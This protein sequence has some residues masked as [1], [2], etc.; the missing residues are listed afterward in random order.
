MLTVRRDFVNRTDEIS[1]LNRVLASQAGDRDAVVLVHGQRGIGKTQLLGKY[2][3]ESIASRLR[4]AYVDLPPYKYYLGVIDEIVEGLGR[5]GFELL[6][7]TYDDLLRRF[8]AETSGALAAAQGAG[9]AAA[10]QGT[11]SG[12][13]AFHGS[14][15]AQTQQFYAATFKDS[16]VTQ[17][18]NFQINEAK[19]VKQL[20]ETRIT[21]A[22]SDCLREIAQGQ[23][24]IIL[25]DHWEGAKGPVRK[26]LS[27]NLLAWAVE[28]R[29]R[30]AMLVLA[31]ENVPAEYDNTMGIQPLAVPPFSRVAALEFWKRNELAED[32][33]NSL[34]AEVYSI[35]SMLAMEVDTRKERARQA[36][37]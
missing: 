35:P 4:I 29:L 13:I 36:A 14:V 15:T 32:D 34:Q 7:Q 16:K 21:R 22:F 25:L 3:R 9:D 17:I 31:L 23:A 20:I 27:E 6:D 26:W 1:T 28:P 33:F 24:L 18:F 8:Q 12:G 37:R 30:M 10:P 5:Q 19:E 2:L 11:Q